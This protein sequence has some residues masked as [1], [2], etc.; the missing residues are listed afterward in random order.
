MS[1]ITLEAIETR[2]QEL[3]ALIAKYKAEA[4]RVLNVGAMAIELAAGEHYAGAVLNDDGSVKH[5]LVLLGDKPDDTLTWQ[6]AKVWAATVHGG[7]PD[8]QEA[9]LIFANCKQHVDARWHWTCEAYEPNAS[10]AWDCIFD[11]GM[12]VLR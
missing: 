7:L 6:D 8:R 4:P 10:F 9:A 2:Q 5:H 1:E 12:P 3:V 11:Y